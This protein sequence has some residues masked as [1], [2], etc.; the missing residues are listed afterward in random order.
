MVKYSILS[1][2]SAKPKV[3]GMKLE[4]NWDSYFVYILKGCKI[5][6]CANILKYLK[7]F[8]FLGNIAKEIIN[9]HTKCRCTLLS[10]MLFIIEKV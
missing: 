9:K 2:Q 8:L 7:P 3:H 10:T 6:Y 1:W 4:K 5:V